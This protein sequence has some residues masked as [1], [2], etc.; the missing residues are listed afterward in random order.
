MRGNTCLSFGIG[1]VFRHLGELAVFA[2]NHGHAVA[3]IV[4]VDVS[5]VGPHE[6]HTSTAGAFEIFIKSWIGDLI[7]M[8]TGALIGD[9]D[10][11]LFVIDGEVDGD[12]F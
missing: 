11:D 8:K 12:G 1:S 10:D 6:H 9:G 5:H 2:F 7:G 3:R 4:E